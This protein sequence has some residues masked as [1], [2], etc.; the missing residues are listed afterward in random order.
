MDENKFEQTLDRWGSN[1]NDWPEAERQAAK[2]LLAQS[3]NVESLLETEHRI[4][5]A[6]SKLRE[7][8][9]SPEL[10]QRIL[11]RL[12]LADPDRDPGQRTWSWLTASVWRP[13]LLAGVPLIFGF[14]LGL[15]LPDLSDLSELSELSEQELADQ[16][17]MLALSNIYQEIDDAQQ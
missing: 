5:A 14:A 1:L 6:L 11:A 12:T 7:H 3:Q 8:T 13:A 17:S 16:V 15:G 9:V 2:T 10:E 4:D